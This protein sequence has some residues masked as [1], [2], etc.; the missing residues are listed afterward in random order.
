MCKRGSSFLVPPLPHAQSST[1][2]TFAYHMLKNDLMTTTTGTGRGGTSIYGILYGEQVFSYVLHFK[3]IIILHY[4]IDHH[5][6][7]TPTCIISH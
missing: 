6:P 7:S 4:F 1:I 5:S 2:I 3:Y